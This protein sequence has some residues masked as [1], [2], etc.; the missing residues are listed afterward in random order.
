M[1]WHPG[2][3]WG[4]RRRP[5]DRR[6]AGPGQ[7]RSPGLPSVPGALWASSL[8]QHLT[9]PE[10]HSLVFCEDG[11]TMRLNF[12]PVCIFV[13]VWTSINQ[14]PIFLL[15]FATYCPLPSSSLPDTGPR[16]WGGRAGCGWRGGSGTAS[17]L[18][19]V[20]AL[21]VA[22]PD[23]HASCAQAIHARPQWAPLWAVWGE[24]QQQMWSLAPSTTSLAGFLIAPTYTLRALLKL[25]QHQ[26]GCWGKGKG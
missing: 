1:G 13:S 6:I 4:P 20:S 16:R 10:D 8:G 9:S 14:L 18:P 21:S 2:A 19:E 24:C 25:R 12:M 3:C 22:W 15:L 23:P 7:A 26:A 17:E 11:L 5:G